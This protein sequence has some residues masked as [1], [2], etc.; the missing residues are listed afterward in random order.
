MSFDDDDVEQTLFVCKECFVYR[1]PP[2]TTAAGYKA[3]D[4]D[5][6]NFIWSGKLTVKSIKEQCIIYLVDPNTGELFATCPVI[7]G[8][9]ESVSDSS[10]YFVIKI[11]DGK[12]HHAFVGMGFTER[13][14]S[15]DFNAALQD[16]QKYIKQKK[17]AAIAVQRL[18]T[19][20]H[21]DYSL[22]EGQKI[23]VNIKS[24]KPNSTSAAKPAQLGSGGLLPPPPGSKSASTSKPMNQPNNIFDQFQQPQQPQQPQQQQQQRPTNDIWSDFTGFSSNTPQQ[25]SSTNNQQNNWSPF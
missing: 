21:K 6:T 3:A 7:P 12:G 16:H 10:R 4:W 13:S 17:E 25:K 11:D 24:S 18:D 20:P 19:M 23:H 22:A 9:V 5:I 2:R 15:F 14:E 8:A 1:L